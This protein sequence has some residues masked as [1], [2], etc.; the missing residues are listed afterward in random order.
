M[1]LMRL[2]IRSTKKHLTQCCLPHYRWDKKSQ[3]KAHKNI[4][5]A[6][7]KQQRAYNRHHTLPTSLTKIRC[8]QK[9]KMIGQK[10]WKIL[11]QMARSVSCRKISKKGLCT[12]RNQSGVELSKTY[13]VALLKHYLDP[14]NPADGEN[15][16]VPLDQKPPNLQVAD[17]HKSDLQNL[18]D[19][20]QKDSN[21]SITN[22]PQLVC[23]EK[24]AGWNRQKDLRTACAKFRWS[25]IQ[26]QW[27]VSHLLQI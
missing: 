17:P 10:R 8:G 22:W 12:L 11:L 6:Q 2:S 18:K 1:M 20:V 13:N 24:I 26:F 25:Y 15:K 21:S 27:T 3:Q 4:M 14:V 23:V 5:K 16:D 7:T 9:S 19:V